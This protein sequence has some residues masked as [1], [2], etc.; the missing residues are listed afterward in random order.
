M[1]RTTNRSGTGKKVHAVRG[2]TGTFKENDTYKRTHGLDAKRKGQTKRSQ[3]PK[4]PAPKPAKKNPHESVTVEFTISQEVE[5]KL[6]ADLTAALQHFRTEHKLVESA[7]WF[8]EKER[9]E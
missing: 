8:T 6:Y 5:K 3:T 7:V 2:K 9:N 4:S 1:K